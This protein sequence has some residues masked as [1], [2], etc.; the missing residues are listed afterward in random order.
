MLAATISKYYDEALIWNIYTV[1]LMSSINTQA[2]NI[3]ASFCL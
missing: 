2:D 1:I 3:V